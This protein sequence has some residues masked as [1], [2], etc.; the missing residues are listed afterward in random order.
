MGFLLLLYLA[1]TFYASVSRGAHPFLPQWDFATQSV[2]YAMVAF[3]VLLCL[4]RLYRGSP[5]VKVVLGVAGVVAT[6]VFVVLLTLLL[7]HGRQSLWLALDA[8]GLLIGAF[9][10]WTCLSSRSVS[11]F[12]NYQQDRTP[13]KL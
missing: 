13:G 6:C 7:V 1:L 2:A 10:S 5:A 3:V 9:T 12:L 4:F 11:G 8:I